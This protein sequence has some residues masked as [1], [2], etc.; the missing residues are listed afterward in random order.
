MSTQLAEEMRLVI[1]AQRCGETV[2]RPAPEPIF[3]SLASR[4]EQAGR[5]VPGRYGEKWTALVNH[6]CWP[7][8]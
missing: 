4:W 1:C 2:Y 3:T 7:R 6:P 8:P 5:L